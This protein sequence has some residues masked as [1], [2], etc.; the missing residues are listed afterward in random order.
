M[1]KHD[2][3][4]SKL[5]TQVWYEQFGLQGEQQWKRN[6]NWNHETSIWSSFTCFCNFI[7]WKCHVSQKSVIWKYF[8]TNHAQ[9]SWWIGIMW[10]WKF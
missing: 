7:P 3:L 2:H 1:H 10:F 5:Q 6:F 8:L 9:W 4:T